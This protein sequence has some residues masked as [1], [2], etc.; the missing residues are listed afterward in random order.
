[1][2]FGFLS[3]MVLF[4]LPFFQDMCTPGNFSYLYI[5]FFLLIKKIDAK[6]K[7]SE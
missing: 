6:S 2:V 4:W 3:C 7:G 5:I 1:M